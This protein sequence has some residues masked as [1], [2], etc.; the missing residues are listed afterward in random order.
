M[1]TFPSL[2]VSH[3]SPMMALEDSRARRFLCQLGEDIG[4]PD[5]ILIA[6][7][8]WEAPQLAFTTADTLPT[9]HDFGGFPQALH[10]CQYTPPGAPEAVSKAAA[11]LQGAGLTAYA[12]PVRGVDHGTWVPLMLMYPDADIPVAQISIETLL[13][14]AHQMAVGRALA[15]LRGDGVLIIGSGNI[16]HNLR[17][18]NRAEPDGDGHDWVV[19][20]GDWVSHCLGDGRIDELVD[21]ENTAPHA[22]RSHPSDEHFLPLFTAL[23]AGGPD[24]A[25]DRIHTSYSYGSLAMDM[26]AFN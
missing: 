8:H 1:T 12:D 11:L 23:G 24:T 6:S 19:E 14:A 16:T 4:R 20:F 17:E 25:V 10:D 21:W 5:A 7:A 22:R 18:M 2:F 15:P 26:Y 13:A 3:G 9:I